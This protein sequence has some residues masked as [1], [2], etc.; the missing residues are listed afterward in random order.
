MTSS[1]PKRI[2]VREARVLAQ[3]IGILAKEIPF[4]EDEDELVEIYGTRRVEGICEVDDV[5]VVDGDL[6]VDGPLL[7][8]MA[9]DYSL[10]V[11]LGN[12]SAHDMAFGGA[13]FVAGNLTSR[14]VVYANS[15]NDHRVTVHGVLTARALVEEGSYVW[16]QQVDAERFASLQNTIAQ[17]RPPVTLDAGRASPPDSIFRPE[18]LEEGDVDGELRAALQAGRPVLSF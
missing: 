7:D 12:L 13:V 15:L 11:V 6:A 8:C 2:T 10:L 1:A 14:G 5:T 3:R 16:A 9:A 17:G 18:I 4:G